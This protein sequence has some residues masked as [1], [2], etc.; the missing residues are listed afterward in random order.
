[1]TK[2]TTELIGALGRR[3]DV[4]LVVAAPASREAVVRE[5]AGDCLDAL[6]PVPGSGQLPI[7]LWERF[8]HA[9]RSRPVGRLLAIGVAASY[10][11]VTLAALVRVFAPLAD[12]AAL[13]P[14]VIA[15]AGLWL[16]AFALF[17][18]VFAPILSLP[19]PD[20]RPG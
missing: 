20:G 15:A 3:G 14:A 6:L 8:R 9:P 10:A 1:M 4:R 16:A 19:R 11:L 5:L 17:I 18:V 2:Y 13:E 12:A 7:A